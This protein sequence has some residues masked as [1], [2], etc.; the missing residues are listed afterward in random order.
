M[1]LPGLLVL[2]FGA[3]T[4]QLAG[5]PIPKSRYQDPCTKSPALGELPLSVTDAEVPLREGEM[6]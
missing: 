2:I 3:V 6:R 4:P 5:F 1:R